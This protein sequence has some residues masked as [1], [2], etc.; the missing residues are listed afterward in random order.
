MPL[1]ISDDHKSL[2]DVVRSFATANDL[3]AGTREALTEPPAEPGPLWKQMAGLGWL[4]LHIPE[5]YGGAGYGLAETAVVAEG[6]GAAPAAGPFLPTVVAA[7]VIAAVGTVEQRAA[8]LPGLADGSACASVSLAGAGT[9]DV[10]G[11]LAGGFPAALGGTWAQLHLVPVGADLAI[12]SAGTAGLTTARV[13]ALDPALGLAR[14][15][16][17]GVAAHPTGLLSGGVAEA[18]RVLRVLAAAEAAGGARACLEMA[19]AYAKIREQFGRIIG[20]FQAVKHHLANMLV[21]TEL[22]TAAAWDAARVT[23]RG[24]EAGLSAAV[25][26]AVALSAYQ[27]TAGMNIQL[28]GG[29]GFTWEHDAHLYLRR[30]ATLAALAGP[31]ERVETDVYGLI[32]AGARRMFAVELPPEAEQYRGEAAAFVA[33]YDA[34]A[35]EDRRTLLVESGYLVPHWRRPWGREAGAVEQLVI[36]EELAGIEFPALGIG[37]WVLLTLT[38]QASAEQIERWVFPSLLGE[39]TWCQLFS[40][41]NAGSDAASVQT[42]GVKVDGGW[43]VTGQKVWTSGAQ[44]CNRGLATIRTDPAAPKHRGI[45]AMVIDLTAPGVR[46]VPLREIT[47]DA[48]FNEVFFDDVFVQDGDVVGEVNQ[49]WT[50]ARATL[51]NER[52]SIGGGSRQGVP[53]ADLVTLHATHA[54]DDGGLAREVG[55][56]V[57][58]ELAMELINL[59]QVERAVSGAEP[60]A[61]GNVTKL[62]SAEHAQ[63]VTELGMTIAAV[64]GVTGDEPE[65]AYEYLFD[66]CLTIAGGTSE[67][68]RNVIAERILGLPRE[69]NMR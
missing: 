58:E 1:A 22:A 24:Q 61:E 19:L 6:L 62:L 29:I 63:R 18:R 53:A 69:Q 26:A 65:L 37:G 11:L 25:A 16:L 4:G 14:L 44:N 21:R 54:A 32:A 67:V 2:S 12:V 36:D 60:S 33:R 49:G 31:P 28:H 64:A 8:L 5:E 3:R 9:A 23:G 41:P 57:A 35:P 30:A 50:V 59:R 48:L 47:G 46:V 34:A 42:R 20:G 52:V 38:Q 40:E 66:R 27:F 13:Q 68:S 45:T 15:D 51:G 55:R 43:Q 56:L 7:A 17:D 39:F 10:A